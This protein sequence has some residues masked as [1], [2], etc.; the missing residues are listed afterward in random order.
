M[1]MMGFS[2]AE[3]FGSGEIRTWLQLFVFT[4]FLHANREHFT[5]KGAERS[6]RRSIENWLLD[7]AAQL[8][9]LP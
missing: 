7:I 1:G 5:R 6:S 3:P 9:R 4:P 8:A 2:T